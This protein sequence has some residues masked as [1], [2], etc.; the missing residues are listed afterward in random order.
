MA[1]ICE[2][3]RSTEPLTKQDIRLLKFFLP[4]NMASQNP[5]FRQQML[6]SL[7][8]MFIRICERS[9]KIMK[10]IEDKSKGE[11]LDSNSAKSLKNL[12]GDKAPDI[13]AYETD[14]NET[15]IKLYREFLLFVTDLAFQCL[16]RASNFSRYVT[17]LSILATLVEVLELSTC[18]GSETLIPWLSIFTK[19]NIETLIRC[20]YNNYDINRSLAL[21]IFYTVP[22][23]MIELPNTMVA[24][25][26][27][28]GMQLASK[29]QPDSTATAAY[30]FRFLTHVSIS[31]NM[32]QLLQGRGDLRQPVSEMSTVD[33]LNLEIV[34]SSTLFLLCQL[35]SE[36]YSHLALAQN[37]L[38]NAAE[39]GPMYG[40]LHSISDIIEGIDFCCVENKETWRIIIQDLITCCLSVAALTAPVVSSSA[41]EGHVSEELEDHNVNVSLTL[42]ELDPS[43]IQGSTIERQAQISQLLLVCCWRSMKEVS[44]LLG[45]LVSRLPIFTDKESGTACS[46][47][48]VLENLSVTS[49]GSMQKLSFKP[50]SSITSNKDPT[51]F[52]SSHLVLEIANVFIEVMLSSRHCGAYE[53]AYN[54]F[55]QICSTL[56]LSELK[57]LKHLPSEWIDELVQ[58]LTSEKR[59]AILCS[60]RRGAGI[61]YFIKVCR[62]LKSFYTVEVFP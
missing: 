15:E 32:I 25:I 34:N 20:F 21:Q 19:S 37:N 47:S 31:S 58:K 5:S 55:V 16:H 26:F 46:L 56:W 43:V 48:R 9:R 7:K 50:K 3:I 39:K 33:I 10:Q 36:L 17:S 14:Q 62:V 41:P 11:R 45:S 53:L 29:P 18:T 52:I 6:K 59:D 40:L 38:L 8:K 22:Q 35:V 12:K 27:S 51:G 23:D 1:L 54:G 49:S 4:L 44:E 13:D 2:S 30:L 28:Q 57:E 61:P 60:T 24:S 42:E